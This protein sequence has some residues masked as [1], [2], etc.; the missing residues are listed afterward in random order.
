MAKYFYGSST[1]PEAKG[2]KFQN[3]RYFDGAKTDASEVLLEADYPEIEAAYK[4][5][6]VPV[7]HIGKPAAPTEDKNPSASR[8]GAKA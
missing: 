6:K 3:H 7:H 5:A 4:A 8:D 1:H 2:F